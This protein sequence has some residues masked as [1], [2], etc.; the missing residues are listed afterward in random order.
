MTELSA[1]LLPDPDQ[2]ELLLS[3]L[4]RVN[5][6]CNA[7]RAVALDQGVTIPA[8]LRP[9][10]KEEIERFKLPAAFVT[11]AVHRV[12]ESITGAAGRRERFSDNQSLT[13]PG[14]ALRWPASDRVAIPT[15]GGKRTVRVY[16][17]PARGNLR[18]PLEGRD[19]TLR[20]RN[21]EFEL[22][23]AESRAGGATP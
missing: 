4:Q 20:F 6:A 9:L 3:T 8:A 13:L 19:V 17:D 12:R 22:V 14:S 10:V 1:R 16:V 2:H 21:G 15:A 7:A 5:R 23:A 18:P 11:P